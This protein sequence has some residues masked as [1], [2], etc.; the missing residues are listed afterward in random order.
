MPDVFDLT[1]LENLLRL[2]ARKLD[3]EN[4]SEELMDAANALG[5]R[6]SD[7]RIVLP[8]MIKRRLKTTFGSI[9]TV[10]FEELPSRVMEDMLRQAGWVR[11]N[12]TTWQKF[13]APGP[14]PKIENWSSVS[15]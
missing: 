15:V 2:A 11:Y 3:D 4:L 10:E 1:K 9:L 13:Y 5:R 7:G 6:E 8:G 14:D 12:E